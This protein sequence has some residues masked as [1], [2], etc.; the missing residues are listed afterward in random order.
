MAGTNVCGCGRVRLC[1]GVGLAFTLG[2]LIILGFGIGASIFVYERVRCV[3]ATLGLRPFLRRVV[4]C[5]LG[6]VRHQP[7]RAE[8]EKAIGFAS[9]I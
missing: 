2:V 3:A 9:G 6:G 1:R 5:W 7:K 8:S 4:A